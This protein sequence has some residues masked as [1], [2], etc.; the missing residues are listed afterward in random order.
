MHQ[1]QSH[2]SAT[3]LH[4]IYAKSISNLSCW[5]SKLRCVMRKPTLCI[6]EAD[7][8]LCFRYIDSTIT[9]FLIRNV[10]PLAIF[11][12]CTAWF[13]ADLVRNQKVGF[14]ITRHRLLEYP[15]ALIQLPL[16]NGARYE[17]NNQSPGFPTRSST[18]F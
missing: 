2:Q 18:L 9:S 1:I 17:N 11:C 13:V 6:C 4:F 12:S 16:I 8:R 15:P 3:P 7:Q 14:L 5:A 10:K